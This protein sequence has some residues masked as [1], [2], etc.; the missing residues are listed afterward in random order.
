[1]DKLK[2]TITSAY[3]NLSE[4]IDPDKDYYGYTLPLEEVQ[5]SY[6]VACKDSNCLEHVNI[7]DVKSGDIIYVAEDSESEIYSVKVR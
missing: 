5:S 4:D 7:E 2:N 3:L 6:Q 1:M